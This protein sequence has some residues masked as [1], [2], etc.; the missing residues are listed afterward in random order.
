MARSKALTEAISNLINTQPFFATLLF[1]VMGLK[2]DDSLG[3]IAAADG[4][5]V[6]INPAEFNKLSL[7]Q[8]V[9]V[10][11]HEIMH[12]VFK[13]VQRSKAYR[14][15]G[16]GPDL[17]PFSWMKMNYAQDYVINALLHDAKL[18]EMPIGCLSHP[19]I[20]A[21]D[22]VDDVYCKIPDPPEKG[23]SGDGDG[24]KGHGG[25]DEHHDPDPN[26]QT[27]SEAEMKRA[28]K[29]AANAAKAQGKL[30][31]SLARLVDEFVEGT[32][33]WKEQ[34][35]NTILQMT[36]HDQAS[37]SKVNRRKLVLPPHMI[38]PG[39]VGSRTGPIA[40]VIDTSG[41]ISD[42]ELSV[43]AGELSLILE[44]TKPENV[45]VLW[46]DAKVHRI[47]ELDDPTDVANITKDIPG[48]GGTDMPVAYKSIQDIEDDI[49]YVIFFTDGYTGYG[50]EP[51]WPVI[52]CMT[53]DQKAPYGV[54]I[55]VEVK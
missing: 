16:F 28:M 6:I 53:T 52:W 22:L 45:H 23:G 2:E 17:K 48:G 14:E 1:D 44:D 54:N 4:K 39:A 50:D 9:F 34:L 7:K 41:S 42:K 47:D 25:F 33:D 31:G 29:S 18:G 13:H 49:S 55:Q 12:N 11:G 19:D 10:L 5:N 8:R 36:G 37:W 32:V 40:V 43:F 51:E 46:T 30:P 20:K 15:R 38:Y 26:A 3:H 21:D 27:P 24:S 35:Q